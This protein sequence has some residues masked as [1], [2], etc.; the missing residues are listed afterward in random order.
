MGDKGE[1]T[2]KCRD[3]LIEALETVLDTRDKRF[4]FLRMEF[5]DVVSRIN[6]EGSAHETAWNIYEEFRKQGMRGSLIACLNARLDCGL[7]FEL[8]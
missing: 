5:R 7:E 4:M 3:S 2:E 8:R 6:L 1:L